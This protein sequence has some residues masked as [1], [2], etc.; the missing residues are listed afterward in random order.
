[1]V[2]HGWSHARVAALYQAINLTLALP[3]IGVAVLFPALAW[4]VAIGLSLFFGLGWY[5]MTK[6]FGVLVQA[7]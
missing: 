7:G 4:P 6:K 1:M 3:G 2:A 5:L